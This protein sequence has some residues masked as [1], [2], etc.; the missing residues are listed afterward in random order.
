MNKIS[1]KVLVLGSCGVLVMVGLGYG[2]Y[3]LFSKEKPKENGNSNQANQTTQSAQPSNSNI[4]QNQSTNIDSIPS[5]STMSAFIDL[6]DGWIRYENSLFGFSFEMPGN[7]ITDKDKIALSYKDKPG[8]TKYFDSN[9]KDPIVENCSY[10][11]F[12]ASN[13]TYWGEDASIY[14]NKLETETIYSEWWT[15][16]EREKITVAGLPAWK[17]KAESYQSTNLFIKVLN[18][19]KQY[20]FGISVYPPEEINNPIVQRLLNSL[21]F[22]E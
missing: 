20:T 2:G 8:I 9:C 15:I 3:R 14:F 22:E 21:K 10:L 1:G 6:G 12:G 7:W 16:L 18:E 17:F 13:S 4:D 11:S 19:N 5:E